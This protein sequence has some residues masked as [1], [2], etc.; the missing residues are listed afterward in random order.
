MKYTDVTSRLMQKRSLWYAVLKRI[1]I[2][3]LFISCSNEMGCRSNDSNY[4]F[5]KIVSCSNGSSYPLKKI[6]SRSN[7]LSCPFKKMKD[8]MF[9][10]KHVLP[11]TIMD[12]LKGLRKFKS[13]SNFY[14]YNDTS[15]TQ[16]PFPLIN[17]GL[18]LKQ[19]LGHRLTFKATLSDGGE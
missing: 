5:K 15:T 19:R 13:I 9:S 7:G 16:P 8:E 2:R 3:K 6:V 1:A 12:K 10:F 17:V 18:P 4:P 11:T 14:C